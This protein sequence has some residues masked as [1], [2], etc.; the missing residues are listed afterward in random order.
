[1]QSGASYLKLTP[2]FRTSAP[3]ID[4]QDKIISLFYPP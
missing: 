1:M 4:T 3:I 2:A